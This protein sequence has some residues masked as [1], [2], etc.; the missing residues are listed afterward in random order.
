MEN[1]LKPEQIHGKK[2][3]A[4]AGYEIFG[5]QLITTV[6]KELEDENLLLIGINIR[7]DDFDFFIRNLAK[8]KVEVTIF[9]PEFQKRSAEFYGVEGYLIAGY[10]KD[11]KMK[12][13]TDEQEIFMDDT[14]LIRVI[15][16]V[17]GV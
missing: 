14:N 15:K 4:V 5:K 17:E 6:N 16:T 13:L 2:L 12:Y 7:N 9:L 11:G 8:S 3:I 1:Q 10:K